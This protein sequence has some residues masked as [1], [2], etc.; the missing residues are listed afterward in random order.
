MQFVRVIDRVTGLMT[1]NPEALAF[2][3][4]FNFK[5]LRA[6]QFHEPRMSQ[7]KRD[8]KSAHAVRRKPLFR[9]PDVWPEFERPALKLSIE[10]LNTLF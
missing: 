4:P 7:V 1:Q 3:S 9:Q 2:A 10:L 8:R 5:H 6:F